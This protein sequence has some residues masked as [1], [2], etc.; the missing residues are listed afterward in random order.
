MPR[1]LIVSDLSFEDRGSGSESF[2]FLGKVPPLLPHSHS[3]HPN[4]ALLV[5]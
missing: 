4:H 1:S 2:E 3:V 5:I